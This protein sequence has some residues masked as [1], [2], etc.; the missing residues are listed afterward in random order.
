ML[1][2][3]CF[4]R[5]LCSCSL[6]TGNREAADSLKQYSMYWKLLK[7]FIWTWA[8]LS[9]LKHMLAICSTFHST[10]PKRDE[11]LA[12][13]IIGPLTSQHKF[14]FILI[15]KTFAHFTTVQYSLTEVMYQQQEWFLTVTWL[16]TNSVFALTLM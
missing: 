7:I 15:T 2:T 12:S 1:P 13:H 10:V 9:S 16:S 5:L 6:M 14:I 11:K 3:K 4:T 8:N